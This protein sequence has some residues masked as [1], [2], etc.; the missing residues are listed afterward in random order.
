MTPFVA[1]HST[2]P[3]SENTTGI[4]GID[5]DLAEAVNRGTLSLRSARRIQAAR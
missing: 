5:S 4:D 3:Y 2:L 1:T